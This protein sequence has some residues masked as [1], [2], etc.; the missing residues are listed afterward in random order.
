MGGKHKKCQE[1][2]CGLIASFGFNKIIGTK[3]PIC[4]E[5]EVGSKPI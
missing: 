3:L 4:K 5:S 2:D 1:D